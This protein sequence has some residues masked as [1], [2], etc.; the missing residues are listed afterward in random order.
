MNREEVFKVELGY[1]KNDIDT[2]QSDMDK[3]VDSI[4][5]SIKENY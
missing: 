1:I 5:K 3:I 2:I 4:V